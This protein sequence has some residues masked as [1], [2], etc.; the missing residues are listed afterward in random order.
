MKVTLSSLKSVIVS[1]IDATTHGM[2]Y[3][4]CLAAPPNFSVV[5]Q[6]HPRENDG[7]GN[8]EVRSTYSIVMFENGA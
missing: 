2:A 7:R 8:F 4:Y 1:G 6:L 3:I 5:C